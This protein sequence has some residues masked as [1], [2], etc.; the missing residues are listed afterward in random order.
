MQIILRFGFAALLACIAATGALA[1]GIGGDGESLFGRQTP[2]PKAFRAFEDGHPETGTGARAV[3]YTLK[4][5]PQGAKL[6]ACFLDGDRERKA[7]FVETA[8][9]WSAHG[10]IS[11]DFGAA[12]DF[13]QCTRDW[14]APIR[15]TFQSD[16][17]F[18]Y[19]GTDAL[20]IRTRSRPTL[21]IGVSRNK[22]FATI[23]RGYWTFTVLHEL[24]HALGLAHEHQHPGAKC[25]EELDWDYTKR[26]LRGYGWSD[27]MIDRNMRR[28]V[29][30]PDLKVTDYDPKSVM[31][32]SLAPAFFKKGQQSKCFVPVNKVLSDGDKALIAWAY[33]PTAEQRAQHLAAQT[34]QSNA[35]LGAVSEP[36]SG[37]A[38]AAFSQAM[39]VSYDRLGTN[40]ILRF[41][42][43]AGA[44]ARSLGDIELQPCSGAPAGV[45][46]EIAKD[47]S[48]LTLSR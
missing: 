27:S 16:V 15:I 32:Y 3:L 2:L 21:A 33:P 43:Q 4:K 48:V 46:C 8:S 7:L 44:G 30:G 1:H 28:L 22:P 18:A 40:A 41:N 31:H 39:A 14:N 45:K 13:A 17:S 6:R 10:N 47:E 42:L 11:F 12:P 37:P 35:V 34:G 9:L 20:D 25:D 23:D 29:A 24:G 19:V 5:W 36:L 26:T 38:L